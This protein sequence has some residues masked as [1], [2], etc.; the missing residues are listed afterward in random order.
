[1]SVGASQKSD[2]RMTASAAPT[3]KLTIS[4]WH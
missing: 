2:A 1:V 3:D 4:L